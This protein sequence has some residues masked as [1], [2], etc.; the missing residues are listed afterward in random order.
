[1]TSAATFYYQS[2]L[3]CFIWIF[4]NDFFWS[5]YAACNFRFPNLFYQSFSK[6]RFYGK[7]AH[8]G[9]VDW[10]RYDSKTLTIFFAIL[11]LLL[12][13]FIVLICV[14]LTQIISKSLNLE[15]FYVLLGLV[16]FVFWL[17]HVWR[18]RLYGLYQYRAGFDYV[19]CGSDP[20][21]VWF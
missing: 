9:A 13:T 18:S 5:G 11:S 6:T 15:P 7:S 4:W 19:C 14:G 12:I 8:H 3:Y 20:I 17:H 21:V 2:R 10:K 1:M 16:I